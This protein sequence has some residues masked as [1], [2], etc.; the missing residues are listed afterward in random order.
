[1]LK[2]VFEHVDYALLAQRQ[3]NNTGFV[4]RPAYDLEYADDMLLL[5]LTTAQLQRILTALEKQAKYDGM[6]LNITKT[7]HLIDPR[8]APPPLN[9][10]D[11]SPV[12]TTTQVKYLGSMISWTSHL[13]LPLNTEQQR[14]RK[15]PTNVK[16]QPTQR[17]QNAYLS[18]YFHTL[19]NIQPRYAHSNR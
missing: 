13:I 9:L 4:V 12:T 3:P 5:A 16:Q 1:M 10:D 18:K 11:G 2:V 15:A 8:R 14:V 7:E 19:F 6:H 17:D